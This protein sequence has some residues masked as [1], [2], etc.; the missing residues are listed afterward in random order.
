MTRTITTL[1]ITT[2]H[3]DIQHISIITNSKIAL[4]TTQHN[5]TSMRTFDGILGKTIIAVSINEIVPNN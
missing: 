3:N 1:N 2:Q 5:D 4:G